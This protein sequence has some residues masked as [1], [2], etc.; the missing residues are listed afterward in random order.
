MFLTENK[1]EPIKMGFADFYEIVLENE[2]YMTE[3]RHSLYTT[4]HLAIINNDLNIL[5]E[6]FVD[7][8]KKIWEW[9]KN[10]FKKV[11]VF[12]LKMGQYIKNFFLR[13]GRHVT[14]EDIRLCEKEG[15]R[16]YTNVETFNFIKSDPMTRYREFD[17]FTSD[18][19]DTLK[20]ISDHNFQLDFNKIK[21]S[22]DSLQTDAASMAKSL[23]PLPTAPTFST[24][25]KNLNQAGLEKFYN[26]QADTQAE[27]D[28]IRANT[29]KKIAGVQGSILATNTLM[30]IDS[31]IFEV[32]TDASDLKGAFEDVSNIYQT[33]LGLEKNIQLD[34]ADVVKMPAGKISRIAANYY[35][36][37][38]VS[39]NLENKFSINAKY[40]Q[41]INK[42]FEK[43]L[44]YFQ[45]KF[46][47]SDQKEIINLLKQNNIDPAVISQII[48]H[49]RNQVTNVITSVLR[50]LNDSVSL[51]GR[52][53][54]A[55]TQYSSKA[56]VYA[57]KIIRACAASARGQALDDKYNID[58]GE[59]FVY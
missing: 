42:M 31:N 52:I 7:F 5:N 12:F 11:W 37:A 48:S 18:L 57:V 44:K 47:A 58:R 41:E 55:M 50:I 53:S 4:E 19:C 1:I 25:S 59:E 13:L 21:A 17:K 23:N 30:T 33:L 56:A 14:D 43:R 16:C 2:K 39:G 54:A 10:F 24:P 20:V 36:T 35:K 8:L 51:I 45:D 6:G 34:T 40:T 38:F 15:S 26:K 46:E 28:F 9:I 32:L 27:Y 29:E 22:V 3:C 49:Y